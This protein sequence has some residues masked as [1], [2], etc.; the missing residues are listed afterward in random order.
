MTQIAAHRQQTQETKHRVAELLHRDADWYAERQ[1]E[2]GLAYLEQLLPNDEW[3]RRQYAGSR[4][5]W[6]WWRIQWQLR[7]ETFLA[8]APRLLWAD[9]VAEYDA[10][11]CPVMLADENTRLGRFMDVSFERMQ[12]EMHDENRQR[13]AELAGNKG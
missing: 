1:Y 13:R 2:T 12:A 8:H 4:S 10:L 5:F 9:R 11:H 7:D 6:A 3:G